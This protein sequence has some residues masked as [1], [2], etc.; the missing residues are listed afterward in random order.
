[1]NWRGEVLDIHIAPNG[2]AVMQPLGEARL[3]A[4][5]GIE[6]DRYAT[7]LGTYSHRPHIDR[8]VTL[9]EVETLEALERDRRIELAPGE[10]RRNMTTRGVPLNHLVGHYFR[11]GECV[12][13]GGRLNV[14]CIHL[15]TLT[16]KKVFKCTASMGVDRAVRRDLQ[17]LLR[18]GSSWPVSSR[19]VRRRS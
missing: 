19:P 14:P 16:G 2:S 17:R 11:V 4:G 13:Y 8:Q 6:G 10:H 1:M 18:S 15:E 5:V 9:I 12:L 7:G 3:M